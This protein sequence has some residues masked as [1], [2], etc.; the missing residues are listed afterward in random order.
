MDHS[1]LMYGP[2]PTPTDRVPCVEN[3]SGTC[4]SRV[5][6]ELRLTDRCR[7]ESRRV[8]AIMR[9]ELRRCVG[10]RGTDVTDV[11]SIPS[12]RWSS[13]S[14]E[15]E[16]RPGSCS[17]IARASQDI[18]GHRRGFCKICFPFLGSVQVEEVLPLPLAGTMAAAEICKVVVEWYV[19][20]RTRGTRCKST[21]MAPLLPPGKWWGCRHPQHSAELTPPAG[22][23][24]PQNGSWV[25]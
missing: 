12:D 15:T 13:L 21:K 25:S 14:A 2:C 10:A 18:A 23:A 4:A 20:K 22:Q 9:R 5:G 8:G 24:V 19:P 6:V 3:P 1:R 11:P 17:S 16:G 7:P